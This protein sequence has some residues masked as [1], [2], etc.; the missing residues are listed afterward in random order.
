MF[1]T[2]L[3][4]A[5][6]SAGNALRSLDQAAPSA[7]PMGGDEVFA[8]ALAYRREWVVSQAVFH[9]ACDGYDH[10][11]CGSIDQRL[12]GAREAQVDV[13]LRNAPSTIGNAGRHLADGGTVRF[14]TVNGN[15]SDLLLARADGTEERYVAPT[16]E[17]SGEGRRPALGSLVGTS[18]LSATDGVAK[19]VWTTGGT[20]AR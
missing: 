2:I 6:V 20:L 9:A 10:A 11:S 13:W 19:V 12:G 14:S 17:L 5:V 15:L 4:A 8:T 16:A 7:Q 18:F 1:N 3:R